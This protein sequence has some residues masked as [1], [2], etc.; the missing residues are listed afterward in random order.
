MVKNWF[1]WLEVFPGLI[2]VPAGSKE[3]GAHLVS[4]EL[5][6]NR[7]FLQYLIQD[8][9]RERARVRRGGLHDLSSLLLKFH[10]ATI[11]DM[12]EGL[13][14]E[15]LQAPD[16]LLEVAPRPPV[17]SEVDPDDGLANRDFDLSWICRR[18]RVSGNDLVANKEK[19][20][21]WI[22]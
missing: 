11:T 18:G 8:G 20:K 5:C 17:Q 22:I 1:L 15:A 21:Q 14:V 2:Q 6:Q 4:I 3:T 16:G 19:L 10:Q 12:K 13:E 9:L 7:I